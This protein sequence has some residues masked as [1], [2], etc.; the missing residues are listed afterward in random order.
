MQ[1]TI[2]V[3]YV[4]FRKRK[5]CFN[6]VFQGQFCESQNRQLQA[7]CVGKKAH[8][9]KVRLILIVRI[10]S[11]FRQFFNYTKLICY[12]YFMASNSTIV[13]LHDTSVMLQALTNLKRSRKGPSDL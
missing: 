9:S 8:V 12:N 11:Q 10:M 5:Q 6:I 1:M 13:H 2:H 3:L 4:T 7:M